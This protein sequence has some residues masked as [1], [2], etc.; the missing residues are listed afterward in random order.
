M[1]KAS[2]AELNN[3][4][5]SSVLT[6]LDDACILFDAVLFRYAYFEDIL[7]ANA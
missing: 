1:Y 5:A 2:E 3:C 4:K 6:A 7:S